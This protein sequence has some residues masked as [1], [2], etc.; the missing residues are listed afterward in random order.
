VPP[1]LVDTAKSRFLSGSLTDA[2]VLRT[3]D[4]D[5]RVT[6]AVAGRAFSDRPELLAALRRRFAHE[7]AFD[8]VVV[9][10]G[11]KPA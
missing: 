3:I 7:T 4:G 11:R 6:A 2:D 5:P 1:S 8:S 10:Y 9:L